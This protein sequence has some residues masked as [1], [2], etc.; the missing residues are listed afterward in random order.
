MKNAFLV[1]VIAAGLLA[2]VGCGADDG[3][4]EKTPDPGVKLPTAGAI[5]LKIDGMS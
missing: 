3:A 1:T 4:P 5:A 2:V